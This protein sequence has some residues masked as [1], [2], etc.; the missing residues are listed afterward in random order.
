MSE[1]ERE[2]TKARSYWRLLVLP[3]SP[4]SSSTAHTKATFKPGS[5]V[6]IGL[7]GHA[8]AA[9]STSCCTKPPAWRARAFLQWSI[10]ASLPDRF[11]WHWPYLFSARW[12]R[13]AEGWNERT[14]WCRFVNW[15]HGADKDR[16]ICV[17]YPHYIFPPCFGFASWITH[18]PFSSP[19]FGATSLLKFY[20][21]IKQLKNTGHTKFIQIQCQAHVPYSE[22]HPQPARHSCRGTRCG[23]LLRHHSPCSGHAGLD[24]E[25]VYYCIWH[26][27]LFWYWTDLDLDESAPPWKNSQGARS[28]CRKK[29]CARPCLLG[30][31][32]QKMNKSTWN[33]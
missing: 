1:R 3:V 17:V 16:Q 10:D 4:W 22:Q 2:R 32:N 15:R 23:V 13:A 30:R 33:Q 29:L 19:P 31:K 6:W 18:H 14:C 25:P 12:W 26:L 24:P 5:L 27:A 8:V 11:Q 7:V 21:P 9:G 20:A 28:S